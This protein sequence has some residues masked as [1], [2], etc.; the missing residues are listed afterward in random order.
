[1]IDQSAQDRTVLIGGSDIA[2]IC[3]LSKWKS[4]YQLWEEKTGVSAR[5]EQTPEMSY[6]LLVE[7][8]LR[9]WYSNATG[10][11]VHVPDDYLRHP[12]YPHLVASP[13]GLTND[14]RVLEIKT[15]RSSIDWGEPGSDEIPVYYRT[16]VEWYMMITGMEVADVAVSFAGSMP[17]LYEIPGDREIQEMILD[18]AMEFWDMVQR[19][20]PP[21]VVTFADAV[22]KFGRSSSIGSV[23]ASEEIEAAVL[24]LRDIR[25]QVKALESEEEQYKAAIMIA[26]ADKDTLTTLEG[27]TLCT[28]K[29]SKGRKTFDAKTFEAENK[30]LY[31]KY[32][33]ESP[34]SR[35]FLVK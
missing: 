24:K 13:D 19:N 21:E 4:A 26:M 31:I 28:W 1:M 34:G 9:Q 33:K 5:G 7:P 17:E 3:G 12:K 8:V 14:G 15:S 23:T 35:R 10:R 30:E 18:R 27:K 16:Q 25:L 29:M 2:P 32:L 11:I 20:E 22:A 6:G